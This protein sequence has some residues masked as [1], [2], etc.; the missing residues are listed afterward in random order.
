MSC[1]G[2][3]RQNTP[4]ASAM[5]SELGVSG[6][7]LAD[8]I[9]G[10]RIDLDSLSDS[11]ID[12]ELYAYGARLRILIVD[13]QGAVIAQSDDKNYRVRLNFVADSKRSYSVVL[14]QVARKKAEVHGLIRF[15]FHVS[16]QPQKRPKDQEEN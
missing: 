14:T 10:T 6:V 7:E 8:E 9:Q 1:R 12:L 11:R 13:D 5:L 15:A 4:S 16:A 2:Q 3:V